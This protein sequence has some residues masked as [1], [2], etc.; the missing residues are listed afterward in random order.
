MKNMHKLRNLCK[1]QS[2][3]MA[4]LL[5]SRITRRSSSASLIRRE[6]IL[7]S[8][9]NLLPSPPNRKWK[10]KSLHSL[11]SSTSSNQM[12][13]MIC[14]QRWE[15]RGKLSRFRLKNLPRNKKNKK[16]NSFHLLGLYQRI[17]SAKFNRKLYKLKLMRQ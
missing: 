1:L 11:A 10:D 13:L 15:S 7:M 5:T 6:V 3:L 8:N 17:K 9:A 4:Q 14:L 2:T 16:E 12:E